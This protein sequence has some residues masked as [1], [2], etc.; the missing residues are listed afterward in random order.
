MADSVESCFH[1][2]AINN[3]S[4][5]V[6]LHF[7]WSQ[8]FGFILQCFNTASLG[9]EGHPPCKKTAPVFPKCPAQYNCRKEGKLMKNSACVLVRVCVL[10]HARVCM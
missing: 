2:V 9:Q 4:L 6:F 5:C 3:Y 1:T 8:C 7:D 10:V